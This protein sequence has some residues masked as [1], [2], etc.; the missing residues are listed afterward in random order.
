MSKRVMPHD[1]GC[2]SCYTK[3]DDMTFDTA[4]DTYVHRACL[5]GALILAENPEAVIIT[6][7][8]FCDDAEISALAKE[9]RK[10]I[11]A[12]GSDV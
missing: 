12:K 10:L 5:V 7:E 2:W 4:F 8:T 9:T 3:M 11:D 1:G 6:E